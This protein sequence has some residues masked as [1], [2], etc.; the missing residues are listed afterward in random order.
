MHH[1]VVMSMWCYVFEKY[2]GRPDYSDT[3]RI[4]NN[5]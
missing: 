4:G 1:Y 2:I 5:F 3:L